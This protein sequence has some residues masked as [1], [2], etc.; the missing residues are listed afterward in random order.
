ML[1]SLLQSKLARKTL[2]LTLNQILEETSHALQSEG[3][4]VRAISLYVVHHFNLVVPLLLRNMQINE[5]FRCVAERSPYQN[6]SRPDMTFL[7]GSDAV[8]ILEFKR[9]R[10]FIATNYST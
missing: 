3:D 5:Q 6:K 4:V 7:V 9:R 2:G 1:P 8:M 10:V